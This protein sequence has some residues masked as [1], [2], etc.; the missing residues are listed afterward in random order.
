MPTLLTRDPFIIVVSLATVRGWDHTIVAD[1]T[2]RVRIPSKC[3]PECVY[4]MECIWDK[5][6]DTLS[7]AIL[8]EGKDQIITLVNQL[9]ECLSS[10]QW[11]FSEDEGITYQF[12]VG[13]DR[14]KKV[15]RPIH[16]AL[17]HNPTLLH[18]PE[19]VENFLDEAILQ[20]ERAYGLFSDLCDG[21]E[22][23]AESIRRAL[24]QQEQKML[25]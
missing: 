25:Q 7:F 18:S 12:A 10:R 1:R 23:T 5:E 20:A 2:V 21:K 15:Y 6:A 14:K 17:I 3:N 11:W 13:E 9:N 22:I 16:Q 19:R 4:Y 8:P 24:S